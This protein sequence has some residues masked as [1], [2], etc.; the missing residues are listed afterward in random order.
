MVRLL[1]PER[2]V[3]ESLARFSGVRRDIDRWHYDVAA[4]PDEREA[5]LNRLYEHYSVP[6][7]RIRD[8]ARR[9]TPLAATLALV[10][11]QT[12]HV[13][14]MAINAPLLS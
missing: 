3:W 1:T 6:A 13:G 12:E 14:S 10:E 4:F 11:G 5:V 2:R 7:P 9:T 8:I